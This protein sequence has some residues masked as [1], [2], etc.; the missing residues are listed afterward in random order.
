MANKNQKTAEQA[1]AEQDAAAQPNPNPASG[2]A[3]QQ[4][5]GQTTAQ[6]QTALIARLQLELQTATGERDNYKAQ[7]EDYLV[8]YDEALAPVVPLFYDPYEALSEEDFDTTL[9]IVLAVAHNRGIVTTPVETE[10]TAEAEPAKEPSEEEYIKD[11]L[12]RNK[13]EKAWMLPSGACFSEAHAR[14]YAGN[15]FDSLTVVT[16]E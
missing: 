7:Y 15:E 2:D 12:R 4:L 8:K 11:L 16:A 5:E 9:E 10:A 1:A 3:T 6:E 13:L 14:E